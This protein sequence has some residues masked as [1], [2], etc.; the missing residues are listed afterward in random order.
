MGQ[1]W[2][3]LNLDNFEKTWLNALAKLGEAFWTESPIELTELLL[4]V[5]IEGPH[6]YGTERRFELKDSIVHKPE[7]SASHLYIS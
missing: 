1:Y 3:F 7:R 2:K 4:S 5:P 6:M